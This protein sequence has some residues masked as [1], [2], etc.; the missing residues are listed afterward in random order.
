MKLLVNKE[1]KNWKKKKNDVLLLLNANNGNFN[2][3]FGV[4]SVMLFSAVCFWRV[5]SKVSAYH[6]EAIYTRSHPEIG[7]RKFFLNNWKSVLL[8][9]TKHNYLCSSLNLSNYFYLCCMYAFHAFAST[10][11]FLPSWYYFSTVWFLSLM[12]LVSWI[13]YTYYI[14]EFSV[15]VILKYLLVLNKELIWDVNEKHKI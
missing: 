13:W 12:I 4:I 2:F 1:S 5:S 15:Y 9:S 3:S 6:C 14:L 7:L 11:F 8:I 10:D